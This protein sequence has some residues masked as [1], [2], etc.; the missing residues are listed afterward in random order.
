MVL[1]LFE[2]GDEVPKTLA[3]GDRA[4]FIVLQ[5]GSE[6]W[7]SEFV[8]QFVKDVSESSLRTLR[9]QVHTSVDHTETIVPKESV[10]AEM[11]ELRRS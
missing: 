4:T 11:R 7:I 6:T 1:N 5:E 10:L 9:G 3:Y 8:D 2:P